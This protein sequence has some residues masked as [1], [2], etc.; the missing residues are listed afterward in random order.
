[1]V[2]HKLYQLSLGWPPALKMLLLVAFTAL[3]L[4]ITVVI[5]NILLE[6]LTQ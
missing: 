5:V 2:L 3:T 1:M 4:T 6:Q